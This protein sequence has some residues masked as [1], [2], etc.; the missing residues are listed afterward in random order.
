MRKQLDCGIVG[1]SL[2]HRSGEVLIVG[3]TEIIAPESAQG[4]VPEG[5]FGDPRRIAS[6]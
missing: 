6:E 1:A 4:D 5:F 3:N 2:Y